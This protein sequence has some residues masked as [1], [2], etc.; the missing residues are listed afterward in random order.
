M[1]RLMLRQKARLSLSA[2]IR[3]LPEP[4]ELRRIARQGAVG[5]TFGTV[6]PAELAG[7]LVP[8]ALVAVTAQV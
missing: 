1:S 4:S 7:A 5:H 8:V 6:N 2:D 3:N